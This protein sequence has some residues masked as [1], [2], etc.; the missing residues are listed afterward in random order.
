MNVP[1][2]MGSQGTPFYS[3]LFNPYSFLGL[4]NPQVS[5]DSCCPCR[6]QTKC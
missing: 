3:F 6:L 1:Q 5:A 2:M 4:F